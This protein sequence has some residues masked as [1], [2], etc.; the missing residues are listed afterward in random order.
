MTGG[1]RSQ[2]WIW[3]SKISCYPHGQGALSPPYMRLLHSQTP[4]L[5]A[6]PSNQITTPGEP[7]LWVT[8]FSCYTLAGI[9]SFIRLPLEITEPGMWA[10]CWEEKEGTGRQ[11]CME[12]GGLQGTPQWR[13]SP[14]GYGSSWKS[15]RTSKSTVCL[16]SGLSRISTL[17]ESQN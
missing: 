9:N 16:P 11:P 5:L 2:M 4:P 17:K 12:R 10:S 14:L 7:L 6:C 3:H 1:T 13:L 8:E 15:T